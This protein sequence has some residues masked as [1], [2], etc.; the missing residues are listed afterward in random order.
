MSENEGLQFLHLNTIL[1]R[2]LRSSTGVFINQSVGVSTQEKMCLPGVALS[3]WL[4]HP[5]S[6]EHVCAEMFASSHERDNQKKHHLLSR[7]SLAKKQPYTLC[8]ILSDQ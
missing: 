5:D 8:L 2:V 4:H 6:S 3:D 7:M 1:T